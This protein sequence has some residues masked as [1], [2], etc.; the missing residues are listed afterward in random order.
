MNDAA[1]S[2]PEDDP[3][4]RRFRSAVDD[5]FGDRVER[6]VLFG[7]RT[8]GEA[9]AGSDYDVAIFLDGFIDRRQE[10]RRMVP[11]V[12]DIIEETGA[13]IHPLPFRAGAWRDRTPLMHEIRLDGVDL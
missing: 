10:V 1:P 3:I 8:R 9:H 7:S 11:V 2:L 6:V 12:T 13:V 4:L 5:L